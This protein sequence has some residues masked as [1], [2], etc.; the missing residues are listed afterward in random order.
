MW[1]TI[2]E[3]YLS[4]KKTS[5]DRI[6][7]PFYGVF[8]LTWLAFNWQP[9]A[10]LMFSELKM[11][12]RIAYINAIYPFNFI[13]PLGISACLAY[14]LPIINEKITYL[15]S[16]PISRTAILLSIRA[17]KALVAD[18]SLEKYRAK[19]DVTYERHV[20]G[21]EKEIQDMR[22]EIVNSKERVGEMNAA[23]LELNQK[24]DEI[25]ALLQDSNIRNKKLSDEIER[26]KIAETRFFGEIEDLNKELDRLYSLLKMEPTRGVGLG[27]RK[28]TTIN[29]E[30]NSDTDDTQYRPGSNE[31]K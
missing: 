21:A 14:I 2:K 25:N 11:E 5:T 29:G 19:R 1:D 31:D 3:I 27:I 7:S 26:H 22:E 17:K 13:I 4:V 24:N 28:I 15:Q 16:R 10:V 8:V 18:I 9:V 30:E 6:K 12:N 20:A 23:L